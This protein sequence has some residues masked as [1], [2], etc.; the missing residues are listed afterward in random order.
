MD[1]LSLRFASAWREV[2]G[3]AKEL[4]CN[5]R[6]FGYDVWQRPTA[7]PELVVLSALALAYGFLDDQGRSNS[8][9]TRIEASGRFDARDVELTKLCILQDMDY[10]LFRIS[11]EMVLRRV[12]DLQRASD[13]AC[14]ATTVARK[15]SVQDQRRPRLS[16]STGTSGLAI[17]AHGVHTPEPSP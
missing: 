11:D 4:P 7:S 10:G 13:F 17:W 16:L 1:A 12:R 2:A 5:N 15:D 3:A 8:N 14:S 6:Y 9:W